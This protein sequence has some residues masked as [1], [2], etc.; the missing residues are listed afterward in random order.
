VTRWSKTP[1]HFLNIYCFSPENTKKNDNFGIF[2]N[3]KKQEL[4]KSHIHPFPR[5]TT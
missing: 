1:V 2:E 3:E 4:K 5:V